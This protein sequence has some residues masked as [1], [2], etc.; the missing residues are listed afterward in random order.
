MVSLMN[1][2]KVVSTAAG[3]A[4][5]GRGVLKID[6]QIPSNAGN[7][8]AYA[9]DISMLSLTA[10][11]FRVHVQVF[12]PGQGY[13]GHPIAKDHKAMAYGNVEWNGMVDWIGGTMG[14]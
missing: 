1:R 13:G 4:T 8:N 10:N 9:W 7:S 12:D 6:C 5:V 3:K 11:D 2:S 14:W